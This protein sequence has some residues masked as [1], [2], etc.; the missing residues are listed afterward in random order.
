VWFAGHGSKTL[1][2]HNPAKCQKW[3]IF[4]RGS[5]LCRPAE[6]CFAPVA[7]PSN[8]DRGK[9]GLEIWA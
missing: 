1:M 5:E 3:V 4:D 9:V 6:F 8:A 7:A 2:I